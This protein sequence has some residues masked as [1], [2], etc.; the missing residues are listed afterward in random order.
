MTKSVA[1]EPC[2][3]ATFE[4]VANKSFNKAL[5]PVGHRLSSLLR[6][7]AGLASVMPTKS[8]VEA[9]LSFINCRRDECNTS[10]CSFS[11]EGVLLA[12][13]LKQLVSLLECVH[14]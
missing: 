3:K 4:E 14:L 12:R 1:R 13:Q 6:F 11:L 2:S 10:L 7:A 5:D 8:R 9:D